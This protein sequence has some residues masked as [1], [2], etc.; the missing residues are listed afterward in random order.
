MTT[1]DRVQSK[2]DVNAELTP[3]EL[4]LEVTKSFSRQ[5]DHLLKAFYDR[6]T[7]AERYLDGSVAI[8][9]HLFP[10]KDSL[11]I[12]VVKRDGDGAP[13]GSQMLVF[14]GIIQ[15]PDKPDPQAS[16][17]RL[18]PLESCDVFAAQ[19]IEMPFVFPEVRFR[20]YND[21]LRFLY[22]RMG[23]EAGK[24]IDQVIQSTPQIAGNFSDQPTESQWGG[25]ID[26][27]GR[28]PEG[29]ASLLP[30]NSD[31]A[32]LIIER[33]TISHNLCEIFNVGPETIQVFPCPTDLLIRAIERVHQDVY[34]EY[35]RKEQAQA[36]TKDAEGVRDTDPD[37]RGLREGARRGSEA[38]KQA[39]RAITG[40]QLEAVASQ[41]SASHHRGG[42][43]AKRTRSSS[44]EDA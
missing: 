33:D 22:D 21:K 19:P 29:S 37:A 35:E 28:R 40:A 34:S 13:N 27:R 24:L 43:T 16:I 44:L 2:G 15:I 32:F 23:I 1:E 9:V 42:Y 20:I 41:K 6:R 4:R 39:S 38:N 17:V 5:F 31:D 10:R 14:V 36:H 11:C 8:H 25:L 12:S 7:V 30:V 3:L 26:E 18:Q